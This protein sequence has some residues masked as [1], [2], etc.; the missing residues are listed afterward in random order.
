MRRTLYRW[1]A[2]ISGIALLAPLHA[3]RR[4]SYGGTLR[5]E[6]A[7]S[8]Q[9]IDPSETK[10]AGLVFETLVRLDDRGR[11]QPWLALSWAH[12]TARKRWTFTPR[13]SVTL[14]NGARWEPSEASLTFPDD[15]P[16]QRILADLARPRNAIAIHAADGTLV[17]TGPFA[18]T[19]WE[20][21]KSATLTS[22]AAYWGG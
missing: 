15:R 21:G 17:G 3:A 11:P 2:A 16:I 7:E 12:D 19:R 18:V 14:H 22:H 4:P 10:L 5:I 8:M 13:P 6:T 20:A 1:I 9:S